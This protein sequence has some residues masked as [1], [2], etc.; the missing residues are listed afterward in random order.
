MGTLK[1]PPRSFKILPMNAL[2]LASSTIVD[3][4][5]DGIIH[6]VTNEKMPQ[7]FPGEPPATAR[8]LDSEGK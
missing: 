1:A 6:P 5:C 8:R 4:H 7:T 2:S 3:L